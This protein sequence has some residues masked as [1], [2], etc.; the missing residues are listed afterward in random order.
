MTRTTAEDIGQVGGV[1]L[2]A[3]VVV[4]RLALALAWWW[5]QMCVILVVGIFWAILSGCLGLKRRRWRV[6]YRLSRNTSVI[7]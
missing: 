1:L 2:A 7:F 6:V 4:A 5:A 3:A